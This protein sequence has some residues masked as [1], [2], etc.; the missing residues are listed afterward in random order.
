MHAARPERLRENSGSPSRVVVVHFRLFFGIEVVEIAEELIEPMVG[1]Q[2]VVQVAEVVLAELPGRIAL[3]LE[4]RRDGDELLRHAD[5][6]AG[7]PTLERP[8]R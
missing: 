4:H 7:M 1:R 2:H 6:R 5:G 3:V 8:V